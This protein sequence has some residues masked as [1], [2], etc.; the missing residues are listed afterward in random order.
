M[1]RMRQGDASQSRWRSQS[2]GRRQQR[3]R[4]PAVIGT[5]GGNVLRAVRPVRDVELFV[6]RL[7]PDVEIEALQSHVEALA[8]V[9]RG[10][11]CDKLPQRRD[12]YISCKVT[13]KGMVREN[14]AELYKADNWDKDILIK[15]WFN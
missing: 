12:H 13:I 5:G 6:T 4:Q 8:G 2:A 15:R 7:S 14:I 1:R 3:G 11:T 9:T 10:V